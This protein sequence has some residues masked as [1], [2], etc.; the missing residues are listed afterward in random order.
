MSK[1]KIK[2]PKRVAGVKIPKAV[3]KGPVLQFVNSSAG[4]LLVAEALTAALGLFAYQ[5]TRG[6]KGEKIKLTAREA[7][8][9]LKRNTARLTFAFGEAVR[10][11]RMALAAP[12]DE[13]AVLDAEAGEPGG[14]TTPPAAKKNYRRSPEA[15]NQL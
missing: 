12:N 9:A 5:Q 6:D 4:K 11:F 15:Q 7:E 8:D 3:R 1:S 2:V 14:A 13:S 10:A